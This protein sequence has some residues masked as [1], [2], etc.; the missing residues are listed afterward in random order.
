MVAR[1]PNSAVADKVG[2]LLRRVA[3]FYT[4]PGLEHEGVQGQIWR[5]A[6]ALSLG[7]VK[8]LE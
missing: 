5:L 3:G 6:D 7:V 2:G 1:I 4:H 8:L